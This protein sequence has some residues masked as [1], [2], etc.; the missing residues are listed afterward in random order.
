M[1]NH[2]KESKRG[3]QEIQPIDYTR[4][5]HGIKEPEE[6]PK[7]AEARQDRLIKYENLHWP[8]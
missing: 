7:K 3:H 5:D 1:Q 6:S 4:N 2:E 8:K